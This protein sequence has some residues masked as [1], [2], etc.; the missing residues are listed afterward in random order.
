MNYSYRSACALLISLLVLTAQAE[1]PVDAER[2]ADTASP[3]DEIVVTG[4]RFDGELALIAV[5]QQTVVD[6]AD[7]LRLLPGADRNY[8]GRI[9]GIA[10][11]RGMFGDRVS[12]RIDGLDVIAGGPNA[13]DT[14]LSYVSPMITEALVLERGI[15]GVASAP[16]AIGGHIDATLARGD[17]G[18]GSAFTSSGMA[19]IR[20]SDNGD[21]RAAAARLTVA[22]R[23][24]RFSLIGQADRA[25]DQSTPAGDILPSE[26]SRDRFDLSYAWNGER[27]RALAYFG[28]LDTEDTGTPA[29]PMDIRFIETVLYGAELEHDLSDS[30]TLSASLGY[31]D[32][33]HL[34]DNFSLRTPPPSPMQFRQNRTGG[35][36]TVFALGAESAIGGYDLRFGV[37][38]RY[39]RHDSLISNPNNAMFA[40]RNFNDIRRDVLSGFASIGRDDGRATW[41][42]GLRYSDV[43]SDADAVSA[44]GMMGMMAANVGQLS[45]AFNA[46]DRSLS[47][48]NVDAVLRYSRALSAGLSVSVDL[49][50]RSRAPAYQELY[51]WLPLQAT[52]GLADG[53]SY[54]GNLALDAERSNE[55][56]VGIE[57]AAGRFSIS[58]Q[59]F[60]KSV[61]DYIQGVPAQNAVANMIATMMSGQPALQFGNVDAELYGVDLGW[62][63]ALTDRLSLD[64]TAG[65]TRGRRTDRSDNL[66]RLPPLNGSVALNYVDSNWSMRAE[67]LA[68]D[69]QDDVSDYN[70]EA[71]TPGYGIVNASATWQASRALRF[72]LHAENLFDRTYQEHLA[73]V[74]RVR[75]VDVPIG[76]RLYG[77]D[78]TLTVAAILEF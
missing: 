33:D 11:Y 25:D 38:G 52:G 72:E 42:F 8:N 62:R 60:F 1:E 59:A 74:N 70:E 47:W 24:H 73:G 12:V 34:M 32:V 56:A 71:T 22:N 39:A 41:E 6:T 15:P 64:G 43:R 49:G 68:Y 13:M 55:I 29:L 66:Y 35:S 9:T 37:D 3:D 45:G 16:D 61:D 17:F 69:G 40:V 44:S 58:P 75:E 46:A 21:T 77:A 67:I 26:L 31:N 10:Q 23:A 18:A 14:P 63:Y 7:A 4:R 20:Y 36:G 65:F 28:G 54:V 27:T 78:R 51:L 48:A 76:E 5:D 53:R 2:T 19:G 57:W 30:T 50:S